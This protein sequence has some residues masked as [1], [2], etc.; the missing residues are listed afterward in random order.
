MI[1]P[2][3]DKRVCRLED[4]CVCEQ[5]KSNNIKL[6]SLNDI[7]SNFNGY[8][9]SKLPSLLISLSAKLFNNGGMFWETTIDGMPA[10]VQALKDRLP[11]PS[12]EMFC[13]EHGLIIT[14]EYKPIKNKWLGSVNGWIK[15]GQQSSRISASGD[16]SDA[17]LKDLLNNIA[18]KTIHVWFNIIEVPEDIA[19]R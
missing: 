14:L 19:T 10:K 7:K 8:D 17:C 9:I 13:K 2:S 12:L 18:G 16:T 4:E 5:G 6:E 3:C 15:N 11:P 1:D